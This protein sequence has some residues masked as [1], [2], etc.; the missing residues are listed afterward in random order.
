MSVCL[1][2]HR[3]SASWSSKLSRRDAEIAE[4]PRQFD[5]GAIQ[6][7]PDAPVSLRLCV[8]ARKKFVPWAPST[9]LRAMSRFGGPGGLLIPPRSGED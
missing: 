3:S 5:P 4:V 6:L 2:F 8:S 9:A 1:D 7:T